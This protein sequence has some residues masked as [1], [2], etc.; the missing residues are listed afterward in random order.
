M[1]KRLSSFNLLLLLPLILHAQD[2]RADYLTVQNAGGMGLFSGGFTWN[3]GRHHRVELS[4]MMG[5]VPRYDGNQSHMTFTFKE[6]FTP[7]W[8]LLPKAPVYMGVYLTGI[9]G[10]DFWLS[11]PS[12]YPDNYYSDLSTR[13]RF[14]LCLGRN[15]PLAVIPHEGNPLWSRLS[16]FAELSTCDYYFRVWVSSHELRFD[17]IVGL[18]FGMRLSL[19]T[20]NTTIL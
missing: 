8:Q 13:Y 20:N 6:T 3:V 12:R 16:L 17:E 11:Q 18:S 2:I 1:K 19:S 10:E 7:R 14:N 9:T 4:T 5:F 15:I